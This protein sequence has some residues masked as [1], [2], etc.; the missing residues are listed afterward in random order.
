MYERILVPVDGSPASSRS[1]GEAID[2]AKNQGSEL[3]LTHVVD[4]GRSPRDG[5]LTG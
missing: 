3:M 4:V 2:L 1:L 5:V